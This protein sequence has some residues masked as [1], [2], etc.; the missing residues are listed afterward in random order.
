MK[1]CY[2]IIQIQHIRKLI[3]YLYLLL[4]KFR[5]LNS[6]YAYLLVV[7]CFVTERKMTIHTKHTQLCV[8]SMKALYV[9]RC[10]SYNVGHSSLRNTEHTQLLDHV[11]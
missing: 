4:A 11:G 6:L 7:K 8:F 3:F 9:L 5:S 1:G 2:I 10:I